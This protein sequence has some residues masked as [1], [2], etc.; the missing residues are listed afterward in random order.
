[1]LGYLRI[2][3]T[4]E[5]LKKSYPFVLASMHEYRVV[6]PGMHTLQLRLLA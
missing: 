5:L 4:F 2:V 1:M 6:V 3:Y